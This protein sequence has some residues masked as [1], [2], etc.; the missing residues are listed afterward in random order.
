MI[1][2]ISVVIPCY[3]QA[4][5]LPDTLNSILAQTYQD[6]ECIM[7]D[8]ESTDNT[9][10]IARQYMAKD[11]RFKYVRQKNRGLS[12]SRNTGLRMAQGEFVF[13]LDSD[14]MV[15]SKYMETALNLFISNPKIKLVYSTVHLFGC[16]DEIWAGP[17][18]SFET[19]LWNN[20]LTP[21]AIFRKI[22]FERAGPY[23][24]N[25]KKGLEDWDFWLS[26]LGKDD[27]VF[28][29]EEPMFLYRKRSLSEVSLLDV[30]MKNK[31]E[32]FGQIY[33]NHKELYEPYLDKIVYFSSFLQDNQSLKRENEELKKKIL[34]IYSSN[35][36][37]LGKMILK[38]FN[39]IKSLI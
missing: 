31:E 36:Y 35:R 15:D 24:E 11:N 22:D 18:Y 33:N 38:P 7:V 37:I 10:D 3:N 5:Y 28:R 12:G 19:L 9:P 39:I 26:M 21:C 1:H 32:T 4:Q 30:A 13:S 29:I 34:S 14:D 23:N 20:I 25:M 27:E 17:K 2:M 6:W 8:D 16:Y